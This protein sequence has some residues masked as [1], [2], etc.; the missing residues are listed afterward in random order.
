MHRPAP[1]DAKLQISLVGLQSANQYRCVNAFGL[2]QDKKRDHF[3][4]VAIGVHRMFHHESQAKNR[5]IK[6][7]LDLRWPATYTGSKQELA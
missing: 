2:H 5:S 1:D 3:G 7:G 4:A 6:P